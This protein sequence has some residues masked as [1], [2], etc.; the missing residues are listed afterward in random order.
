MATL[1]D[2]TGRELTSADGDGEVP[3]GGVAGVGDAGE[4]GVAIQDVARHA[5]VV[6]HIPH[7]E[8]RPREQAL[9]GDPG[10][11]TRTA[12]QHCGG[13]MERVRHNRLQLIGYLAK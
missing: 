8:A 9:G 4:L 13:G 1:G 2:E 7:V 11:T 12:L 5:R 6:D 10:V 3:D